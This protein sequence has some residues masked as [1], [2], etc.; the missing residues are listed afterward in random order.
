MSLGR[1]GVFTC[2][3]PVEFRLAIPALDSGPLNLASSPRSPL[4][5][6]LLL[7]LSISYHVK[8]SLSLPGGPNRRRL[9]PLVPPQRALPPLLPERLVGLVPPACQAVCTPITVSSINPDN[10]MSK[11]RLSG[12]PRVRLRY[13]LKTVEAYFVLI[14]LSPSTVF[15]DPLGS[16]VMFFIYPVIIFGLFIA[17][18][19]RAKLGGSAA[20]LPTLMIPCIMCGPSDSLLDW[21]KPG[22]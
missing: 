9:D 12:T 10:P 15:L 21:W 1:S 3:R 8:R 4:L 7:L 11:G 18:V 5:L 22:R 17:T 14:L 6:L 2:N 16:L 19:S 13:I 20:P